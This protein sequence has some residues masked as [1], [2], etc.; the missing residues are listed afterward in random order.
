MAVVVVVTVFNSVSD[1]FAC[2][3]TF[4]GLSQ[5]LSPIHSLRASVPLY[6]VAFNCAA[7]INIY[8]LTNGL[9]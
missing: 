7:E 5:Q 6:T 9:P 3:T 8:Q 2:E 1:Q 4:P